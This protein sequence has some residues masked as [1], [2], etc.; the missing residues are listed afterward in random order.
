MDL[1]MGSG[2]N[3]KSVYVCSVKPFSATL[4]AKVPQR[5]SDLSS[6]MPPPPTTSNA[7]S[8]TGTPPAAVVSASAAALES[9]TLADDALTDNGAAAAAEYSAGLDGAARAEIPPE[10]PMSPSIPG[11]TTGSGYGRP[12]LEVS[13]IAETTSTFEA[14]GLALRYPSSKI[15]VRAD[16]LAAKGGESSPWSIDSADVS[17]L[18]PNL[19]KLSDAKARR[20]AVD[21]IDAQLEVQKLRQQL[22]SAVSLLASLLFVVATFTEHFDCGVCND[23]A[24]AKGIWGI[25]SS[26]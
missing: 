16:L 5:D 17:E 10:M 1:S 9:Y 7:Y 6:P 25:L 8:D 4:L 14:L 13:K 18:Y 19:T 3:L 24:C 11:A 21:E 26:Q 22:E 12:R 20:S 15:F 2:V 23:V